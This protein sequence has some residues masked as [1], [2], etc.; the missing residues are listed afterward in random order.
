MKQK[1]NQPGLF[2]SRRGEAANAQGS[3]E[4]QPE[5]QNGPKPIEGD[6]MAK[7]CER[8]NLYVACKRVKSNK[9][10]AGID[11]MTVDQLDAYLREHGPRL[12]AAL[13]SGGYQ[14]QPIKSVSIP[15]PDGS[16]R[17]L[18][19]PTVVDRYVQQ[20]ILQ[21]LTPLLDPDFSPH[22]YGFRPGRSGHDAVRQAQTYV[23]SGK[24]WVVDVDLAKFFDRVNHDILMGRLAKRFCDKVLLRL[25][26]RYLEAGM[27]AH[28]VVTERHEGTPQGGPLSPLLANVLLDEVDLELEQRGHSFVR[29][30]DDLNVYVGSKQ[31]GERVMQALRGMYAKLRLQVNESKSAVAPVSERKFLGFTIAVESGQ[32]RLAVSPQSLARFKTK[33]R[34][35]TR[36]KIGQ[37]LRT[38]ISKLS[39]YLRG[40][41]SYYG[42]T[43]ERFR[44]GD[45][46]G[47]IRRRLRALRL[48]QWRHAAVIYRELR[49]LGVDDR[50]SREVAK[51]AGRW[52]KMAANQA[53]SVLPNRYFAKLGLY[54][55]KK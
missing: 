40:W 28:G 17:M 49:A 39:V 26:R 41:G 37:S 1:P 53:N 44:L 50:R 48:S 13:L 31:A 29:Y 11:G 18:G 36:R 55:L 24:A 30:A 2:A 6:L 27:F 22:S 42:I 25:I 5:E 4:A 15:K 35:M 32:A 10:K 45:L 43:E 54:F 14:P 34:H 8:R 52:A 9:G 21:V 23:Q 3:V 7:V 20:A 19:I 33:V 38:V 12:E 47:W 51:Y 16:E 46:D